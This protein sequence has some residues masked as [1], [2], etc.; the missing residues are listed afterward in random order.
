M[1]YLVRIN[2]MEA[3]VEVRVILALEEV[4]VKEEGVLAEAILLSQQMAYLILAGAVEDLKEAAGI[5]LEE[6][7]DQE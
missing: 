3:A 1:K 6:T 5:L 7:A 4:A 2:T